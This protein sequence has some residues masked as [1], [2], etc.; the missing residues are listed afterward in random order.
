[1][2]CKHYSPRN[3]PSD[4]SLGVIIVVVPTRVFIRGT[5]GSVEGEVPNPVTCFLTT[6][7]IFFLVTWFFT[8]LSWSKRISRNTSRL[9]WI[10]P[11]DTDNNDIMNRAQ[12]KVIIILCLAFC[13]M[14]FYF[15]WILVAFIYSNIIERTDFV[16]S[17]SLSHPTMSLR[18]HLSL[19]TF[20]ANTLFNYHHSDTQ[21]FISDVLLMVLFDTWFKS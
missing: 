4:K 6:L 11:I 8:R 1:M 19:D 10:L 5:I 16:I 13:W 12:E 2:E 7:Q 20:Y 3:I 9:V 21:I 17:L 14:L 18:C 15:C